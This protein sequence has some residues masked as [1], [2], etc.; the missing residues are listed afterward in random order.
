MAA[1]NNRMAYEDK[2]AAVEAITNHVLH[3]IAAVGAIT[4]HVLRL[5]AVAEPPERHADGNR[6]LTRVAVF[7]QI[8][9]LWAC[10]WARWP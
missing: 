1:A 10:R 2:T 4:N 5:S 9:R 8:G 6:H 3:K 7:C